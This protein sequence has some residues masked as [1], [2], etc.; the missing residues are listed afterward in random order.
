[1]AENYNFF[2]RSAS[3]FLSSFPVLKKTIKIIYQRITFLFYKKPFYFKSSCSFYSLHNEKES[4]FG[5][6]DKSP[7]NSSLNHY[8][9]CCTQEE[10]TGK[11]SYNKQVE[12]VLQAV[13]N[14]AIVKVF[15]SKAYNWQ[16]GCRAHWLNEDLFF[17]N[18]FDAE[19]KKYISLVFSKDSLQEVRA[20]DF[21]VQDSYGT[22]FFLSLNYRRL[23]ALRPDYGYSNLPVL[24]DTELA[25]TTNDGIWR[26]EYETGKSR[27]LVSLNDMCAVNYR[28][29]FDTA[30]HKTNHVMISPAGDK[31]IF[32]HRF[33][34][35]S[36]QRFDRLMLADSESGKLSCLADYGMV[37]HCFW[38]DENTVLGYLRG[39][40]NKDAYWL[41][42]IHTGKFSHFGNG[43]L[44]KY[45]DGHPHVH[46]DWFVTDTYPDKARMQRLILANW[47]TGE[48]KE[49][50]EFFHGFKYDGETRCD[51]HP[52]FS[53]DGKSIYF[54]SVFDGKRRLYKLDLES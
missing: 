23:M 15:F 27:L 14:A 37:S 53:P 41:I 50:G 24:N 16:Q 52:R 2:E 12:I 46:G 44:D 20:F 3:K 19:N 9:F 39:P 45:G 8:L 33:F 25:D 40:G 5:Y 28:S 35:K 51:L 38:A 36:K 18:D 22:E 30:V 17:F 29:E 4:Y 47:K 7:L 43:V 21:P 34:N 10:T 32:M 42:D 11:P 54:D 48:V 13:N 31:F 26:I 1:M 6:Y 49:L